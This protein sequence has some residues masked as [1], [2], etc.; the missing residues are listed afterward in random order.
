MLFSVSISVHPAHPHIHYTRAYTCISIVSRNLGSRTPIDVHSVRQ[1]SWGPESTV[2]RVPRSM[3]MEGKRGWGGELSLDCTGPRP[4]C[5]CF[6]K[7]GREGAEG[8]NWKWYQMT[9]RFGGIRAGAKAV[10]QARKS[11]L[12]ITGPS[13][14]SFKSFIKIKEGREKV[15]YWTQATAF[16]SPMA[17]KTK[18]RN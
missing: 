15:I 10:R 4:R 2:G 7:P 3:T 18:A 12:W 8:E 6:L 11:C 9:A 17:R 14:H 13:W 16:N 5:W 1:F